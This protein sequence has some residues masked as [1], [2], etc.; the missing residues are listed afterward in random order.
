MDIV[1]AKGAAT[2]QQ[3]HQEM[4]DAASYSALR[5]QMRVLVE[6]GYLKH[7]RLGAKYLFKPTISATE[8]RESALTRVVRAF[9]DNSPVSVVATLLNSKELKISDEELKQL[10]SLINKT[11]K[12]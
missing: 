11:K 7:E 10:R 2:S 3:V 5:A 8:A 1:Y 4:P 9:F 12:P 6:K